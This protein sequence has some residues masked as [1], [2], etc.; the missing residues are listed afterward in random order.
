MYAAGNLGRIM[1]NPKILIAFVILFAFGVY[2]DVYVL[3]ARGN[4]LPDP[5]QI[6]TVSFIPAHAPVGSKAEGL[7]IERYREL[8]ECLDGFERV[9]QTGTGDLAGTIV[10]RRTNGSTTRAK[11][12]EWGLVQTE[13][14]LFINHSSEK[15]NRLCSVIRRLRGA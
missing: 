12:Y 6:K 1:Q 4:P 11:L 5:D 13:E 8:H 9:I 14:G 10:I 7:D 3:H 2:A 15:T